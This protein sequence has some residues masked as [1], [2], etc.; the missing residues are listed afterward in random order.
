[1]YFKVGKVLLQCGVV[2]C[3]TKQDKWYYKVPQ[4]LKSWAIFMKKWGQILQR[5][6]TLITTWGRYSNVR[7]VQDASERNGGGQ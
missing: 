4:E 3:I 1:M 6:E 7:Q 2:F 5:R